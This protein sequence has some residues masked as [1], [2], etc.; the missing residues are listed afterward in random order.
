MYAN[1]LQMWRDRFGVQRWKC[2]QTARIVWRIGVADRRVDKDGTCAAQNLT[3]LI[4]EKHSICADVRLPS[5]IVRS[6][7]GVPKSCSSHQIFGKRPCHNQRKRW[8]DITDKLDDLRYIDVR[9][10][11]FS[12][13]F[14]YEWTVALCR[15][16]SPREEVAGKLAEMHEV[17]RLPDAFSDE[18]R[19]PILHQVFQALDSVFISHDV[20]AHQPE[21][22]VRLPGHVVDIVQCLYQLGDSVACAFGLTVVDP[23]KHFT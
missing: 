21:H 11:L 18:V 9:S 12:K 7:V 23:C 22:M 14:H 17:P 20:E 15:S 19:Q 6:S 4:L 2:I 16:S 5:E 13:F 3:R 10:H 8:T 1:V